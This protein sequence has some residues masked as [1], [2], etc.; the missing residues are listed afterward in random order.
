MKSGRTISLDAIEPFELNEHFIM[1]Y[2]ST[3]LVVGDVIKLTDNSILKLDT[4]NVENY[5]HDRINFILPIKTVEI[6]D[7]I[8]LYEVLKRFDE[9]I[10]EFGTE[11]FKRCLSAGIV[12]LDDLLGDIKYLNLLDSITDP[13]ATIM[14]NMDELQKAQFDVF[15][16]EPNRGIH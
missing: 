7:P 1:V 14:D 4:T 12:D 2:Y 13:I 3:E 16:K 10:K 9:F 15:S 5:K 6:N 8:I 11:T